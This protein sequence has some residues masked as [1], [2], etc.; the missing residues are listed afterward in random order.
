MAKHT[1]EVINK[2]LTHGLLAPSSFNLQHWR[3]HVVENPKKVS[4]LF[5]ECDWKTTSVQAPP[6]S[7]IIISGDYSAW[8]NAPEYAKHLDPD[9]QALSLK[10][11]TAVY[12][13][14]HRTQLD[15]AARSCG[16]FLTNIIFSALEDN[17]GV[18]VASPNNLA[19]IIS[20]LN[21]NE[22]TVP[23]CC[24]YL[25]SDAAAELSMPLNPSHLDTMLA[26]DQW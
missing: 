1:I 25:Y 16:F 3:F 7:A 13:T 15:E 24:V 23:L 18:S 10:K 5:S 9:F 21:L 11:A 22:A 20:E 14:N 8:E 26:N 17:I 4:H 6:E 12:G 19:A 2:L